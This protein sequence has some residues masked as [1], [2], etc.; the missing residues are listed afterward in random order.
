MVNRLVISAI[1]VL[2]L[3]AMATFLH[4]GELKVEPTA[5]G[6]MKARC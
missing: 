5:L 6:F 3:M 1:R 2:V 4:A